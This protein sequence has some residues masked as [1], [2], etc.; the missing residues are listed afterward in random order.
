MRRRCRA[1]LR[2]PCRSLRWSGHL[3]QAYLFW[4]INI[5]PKKINPSLAFDLYPLLR[6]QIWLESGETVHV[7]RESRAQELTEALWATPM[8]PWHRR[9]NILGGA[10]KSQ[11]L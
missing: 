4:T 7:Y 1:R 8:S 3:L 9:I 6:E 2:T 11:D 10:E 5:K